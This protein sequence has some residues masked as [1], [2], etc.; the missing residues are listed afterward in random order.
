MLSDDYNS[1]MHNCVSRYF[2]FV[3]PTNHLSP[4]PQRPRQSKNRPRLGFHDVLVA[5]LVCLDHA[6]GDARQFGQFLLGEMGLLP[7]GFQ[8]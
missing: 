8:G 4:T 2:Y 6:K 5:L 3:L 7:N 1:A